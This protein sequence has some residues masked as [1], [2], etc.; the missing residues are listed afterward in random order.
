MVAPANGTWAI[1]FEWAYSGVDHTLPGNGG[2]E[3]VD[4]LSLRQRMVESFF[5][6]VFAIFVMW[7]GWQNL[8]FP[9]IPP[10]DIKPDASGKRLLLVVLCLVFGVELGFKFA[11]RQM[12]YLLNP[13]HLATIIQVD[14]QL[15][16][17][18][19]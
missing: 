15:Y 19:L 3:C 13:C 18:H 14:L 10:E 4:Y 5:A 17:L 12:I 9:R 8:T 6:T 7:K 16:R 1:M 2:Q 11:T